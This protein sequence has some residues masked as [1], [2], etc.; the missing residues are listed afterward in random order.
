[1]AEPLNAI[2]GT[3]CLAY[4][5]LISS[6]TYHMYLDSAALRS[7]SGHIALPALSATDNVVIIRSEG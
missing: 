5:V 1:M 4:C 2:L 7:D 6:S 3:K